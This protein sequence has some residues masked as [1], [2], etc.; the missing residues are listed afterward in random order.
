MTGTGMSARRIA[1]IAVAGA[2]TVGGLLTL[3]GDAVVTAQGT[4]P[5]A[6]TRINL[7]QQDLEFILAQIQIAEAHPSGTDTLCTDPNAALD[8][9]LCVNL[10]PNTLVPF[11]LRQTNG[12][13]NNVTPGNAAFGAADRVFPR[14]SPRRGGWR[15]TACS[16]IPTA[17]A[18]RTSATPRRTPRTT[19]RWWTASR[20]S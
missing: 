14:L 5:T 6:A 2:I 16:S 7:T 4:T 18:R 17:P 8:P 11:G 9:T 15:P 3:T 10:I 13:N 19:A 12:A 20:A 1:A